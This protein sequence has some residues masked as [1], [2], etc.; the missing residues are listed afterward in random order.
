MAGIGNNLPPI[1]FPGISSGIDYNSIITKL[2]SLTLAPNIQ[3]NAQIGTINAANLELIKINSLLAS[4]Q[5][6]LTALSQP[7]NFDSFTANS[8]NTGVLTAQGIPNVSATP[9]TYIIQSTQIAT[10]TQITNDAAAGHKETDLLGGTPSDQLPLAQS[11]AAITPSNGTGGTG[12]VTIDGHQFSYDVGSQSIDTIFTQINSYF[13]TTVGDASFH[14]GFQAG[15]DKV[16]VTDANP[17]TLGSASDSGNL[18]TV[19]KLDQ[20][21]NGGAPGAYAVDATSG[22]GGINQT[23]SFNAP[24]SAGFVTPVTAGSFTING[25]TLTVSA[26]DALSDVINRI[27][28]S[29]AGVTAQFNA[30][31]GA[32]TLTNKA[33][34]PQSIVLGKVGDSSNFLA[35]SGLTTGGAQTVNGVQSKVVVQ[36]PSGIPQTFYGNSNQVTS[37]IPGISINLVTTDA[38]T[39]V[40]LTV[41]QDTTQLVS[42]L[43]TFVSA[44]NAA[45]GEINSAS[46]APVVTALPVGSVTGSQSQ[47]FSGGVL[48]GNADI[49]GLKDQL[50]NIVSGIIPGTGNSFN[51]LAQIGLQLDSS[52]SVLT[53]ANN[54]A[55]QN[56]GQPAGGNSGSTPQPVQATTFAGTDGELQPLNVAK[57]QAALQSNPT[58]VQALINGVVSNL[59]N[60]LGPVTG[61]PTT[62][63][64]GLVGFLPVGS[65]SIIQGFENQN[66]ALLASLQEQV[67]QNTDNANSQADSLRKQFVATEGQLA[68]YQSLQQQLA[69]FFK[70]TGG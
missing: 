9:G 23:T 63:S 45:V 54:G 39:P 59:G 38:S 31:S 5:G 10:A 27:N 4:V 55:Q 15:T 25:V 2:T 40:T 3:L 33:T 13:N 14:I 64:T 29:A 43:T 67:K 17:I 32:L 62:L 35:A 50:Q 24:N 26:T 60:Y 42:A 36:G 1:S 70:G 52:F 21:A 37:A 58:Q 20:A 48:Y 34:G 41:G 12:K 68:V 8:S 46:A 22:V 19:L 6:S 7:A 65:T 66:T 61:L 47:Q 30:S 53:T 11:Y 57:L 28:S 56:G 69:G 49:N 16:A 18:L 51:S 44:Y